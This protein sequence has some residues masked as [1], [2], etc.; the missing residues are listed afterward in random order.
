MPTLAQVAPLLRVEGEWPGSMELTQG[1]FRATARPWNDEISVPMIRLLRGGS[2]FLQTATARLEEITGGGVLSPALYGSSTRPW[3]NAGYET[4]TQLTVMEKS[5]SGA[6]RPEDP[7][8]S[9]NSSPA[10]NLIDEIDRSAFDGFWRMS[11][12]GLQEALGSMPLSTVLTLAENQEAIGYALVGVQWK[13]AYLHR[14]AVRSSRQRSGLGSRLLSASENWARNAGAR[15]LVLN[16]RQSNDDA[17]RLYVRRGFA[18]TR[19][20]LQ[21]LRHGPI[22]LLN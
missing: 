17:Q 1:W 10:W 5:L 4:H 13:T 12:Q 6:S 7:H 22:S 9:T 19:T 11:T 2:D 15:S 20:K 8:V 16:V 18:D 21:V 3:R 14:I